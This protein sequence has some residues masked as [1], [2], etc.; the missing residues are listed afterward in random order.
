[1]S[2]QTKS[3]FWF[4]KDPLIP[5]MI[6]AEIKLDDTDNLIKLTLKNNQELP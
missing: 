6:L 4:E 5:E 2:H 1:M 3:I